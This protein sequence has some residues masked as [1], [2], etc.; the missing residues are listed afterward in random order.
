[1]FSRLREGGGGGGV[2]SQD[3]LTHLEKIV[4]PDSFPASRTS[5]HCKD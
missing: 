3:T 5:W 2:A 1:M 4:L